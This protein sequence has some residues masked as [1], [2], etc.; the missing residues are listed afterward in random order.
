MRKKIC[1]AKPDLD[2]LPIM[3]SADACQLWG[4]DGSTLRKNVHQFPQG[5]IRKM[6]RDWIVTKDGMASVFGALEARQ[7]S[8]GN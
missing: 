6:G 2:N 1:L 5:T 3:A 8:K 4:I 7:D